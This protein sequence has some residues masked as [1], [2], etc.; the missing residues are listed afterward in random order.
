MRILLDT[1]NLVSAAIAKGKSRNLL[2]KA[3]ANEFELISSTELLNELEDV[4]SRSKF[5]L[6][7]FEEY[8]FF[9]TLR[10][11]VKLVK[12]KAD[13]KIVKEDPDDDNV[14]NTAYD[15]KADFIVTGDLDLLRLKEFEGIKIVTE[16]ELLKILERKD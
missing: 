4:I 3:L 11:T 9:N 16:S 6:S 8:K 5:K 10:K 13:F 12:V 15:G 1:N 14:L 7:S 2:L